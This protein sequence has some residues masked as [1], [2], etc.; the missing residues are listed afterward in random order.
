MTA[1]QPRPRVVTAAFWCWLAASLLLIVFGLLSLT[2]SNFV[3][4]GRAA[5]ALFALTGIALAF[6]AGRT[7]VADASFRRAAIAFS[8]TLAVLLAAYSVLTQGVLWLVPMVLAIVGAG[9]ITRPAATS[10]YDREPQ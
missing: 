7:R 9:L 6:L 8:L 3:V 4:F 2:Q 5:G 10:W 1:P